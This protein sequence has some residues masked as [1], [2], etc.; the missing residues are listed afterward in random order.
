[1][2]SNAFVGVSVAVLLTTPFYRQLGISLDFCD[3]IFTRILLI[4]LCV[5]ATTYGPL[6]GSL[7]TLAVLNL[8][9]ERNRQRFT[10]ALPEETNLLVEGRAAPSLT[11][12]SS[13]SYS[14]TPESESSGAEDIDESH[15]YESAPEAGGLDE[16]HVLGEAPHTDDAVTFF[17][18]KGLA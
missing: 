6:P 12:H 7:T 4:A 8:F 15:M 10:K 13:V 2:I 16:K 1:M 9:F 18:Q 11:P 3:W 5:V 14:Y 17:E